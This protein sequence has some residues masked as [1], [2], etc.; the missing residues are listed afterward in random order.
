MPDFWLKVEISHNQNILVSDISTFFGVLDLQKLL[1][2]L[3]EGK[4]SRVEHYVTSP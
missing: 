1:E 2:E 3:A 4:F